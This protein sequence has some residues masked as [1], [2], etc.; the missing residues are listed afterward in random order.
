MSRTCR[1][2]AVHRHR[3]VEISLMTREK[4]P[5]HWGS[6]LGN[7]ALLSTKPS[8]TQS[9]QVSFGKAKFL[10]HSCNNAYLGT[11]SV[12]SLCQSYQ[13]CHI[14]RAVCAEK[15]KRYLAARGMADCR[16][17]GTGCIWT[18]SREGLWALIELSDSHRSVMILLPL[19]FLGG[20]Q[21]S[22]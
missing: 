8:H 18:G 22:P 14:P 19:S 4:R 20:S 17:N 12:C 13:F 5:R 11:H 10:R 16:K 15:A 21:P 2:P 6:P 1:R 9:W 7:D 3:H